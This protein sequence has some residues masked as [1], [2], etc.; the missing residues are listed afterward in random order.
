M[1]TLH[2]NLFLAFIALPEGSSSSR[3]SQHR[4]GGKD[5][6]GSMEKARCFYNQRSG[7]STI[8]LCDQCCCC[9]RCRL[10][11]QDDKVDTTLTQAALDRRIL[12]LSQYRE[13]HQQFIQLDVAAAKLATNSERIA[14][15][16]TGFLPA[17]TYLT[18]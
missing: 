16:N 9:R 8:Y 10:H 13:Y 7:A 11:L 14:A 6:A 17:R 3:V 4:Q 12:T 18:R 5:K 15:S 1:R 2:F